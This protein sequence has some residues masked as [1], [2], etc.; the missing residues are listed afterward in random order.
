M[1]NGEGSLIKHVGHS[2][3]SS[4][5]LASKSFS[6]NL[7]LHV[8]NL[9]EILSVS[10]FANDNSVYFEFHLCFCFVKDQVTKMTLLEGRLK[11]GLC[12]FELK[13]ILKLQGLPF[14]MVLLQI[15]NL[16]KGL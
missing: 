10:K 13:S 15:C 11:G 9:S 4:P 8:P 3:L 12:V 14:L 5:F 6:L 1:S 2:S 7:L 16:F